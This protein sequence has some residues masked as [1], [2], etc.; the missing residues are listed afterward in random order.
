[1]KCI[2]SFYFV[3]F[4]FCNSTNKKND[5]PKIFNFNFSFS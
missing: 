5:K 1:M 2:P 4:S 3:K